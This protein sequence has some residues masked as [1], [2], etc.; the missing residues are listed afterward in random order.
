MTSSSVSSLANKYCVGHGLE[1]G[2]AAHNA[3]G[4]NTLNVDLTD[5]MDTGF[6]QEEIRRCG[7]A[8]P[9]DIVA[10]GDALPVLD[11]SQDFVISS[12]VIE[13][14]PNPIKAL[15]EW[16]RVIRTGG[17]IFMIIPHKDR[18]FDQGASCT[19]LEHLISDYRNNE[20]TVNQ[21]SGRHDHCWLPGDITQ[22][23]NW[24]IKEF[25]LSWEIIDTQDRDDK[26]GNG[27]TVVIRKISTTKR[28]I[29]LVMPFSRPENKD[30]LIQMYKP[31]GITLYPIMFMDE[32][33][34]WGDEPWIVPIM[35]PELSTDCK[36]MMP[37]CYKRNYYISHY[38]IL[39][40]DYY[41]TV[42]DDDFYESN[43]FSEIS[44]MSDDIVI[45]S[46]KRG[47][48][49]PKGVSV[50]RD[51]PTDTLF[52][53]PDN[54]QLGCISAQQPFVKGHIFRN[55]L[56]NESFHCWDGELIVHHRE[57][58]EQIA[59]RPD[60]YALFNYF[61]PGRWDNQEKVFWGC[62]VND[63]QRLSMVLQQSQLS[64]E[65]LNFIQNPESA[66]KGLNYLLDKADGESADIAIL[67][68]QDMYFT[69]EWL[70]KVRSQIKLLPDN[71]VA[72]GPIGKDHT[73]L[74]C[75]KFHDTRIPDWFDTSDIHTFPCEV[76]CFDEAVLIINM[77]SGFRFDEQLTGFDLYGTL[78]ALQAWE[79]GGSVWVIDA[80]CSH[81]CMRSF[82]WHP[83]QLFINNYRW[84]FD[85]F[86]AKWKL[87]S[88][89]LGLSPDAEERVKQM[90]EFMTSAAP[91]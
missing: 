62:M 22:L 58:N 45:I 15:L 49:T 54:V 17:V 84:L 33:I 69:H 23:I 79:S 43:V 32:I 51:Y 71:W 90:R 52:A 28:G 46:M 10:N 19:T 87:D 5:S 67:V 37:G 13:H 31:L 39:P 6:K 36:V 60:L 65:K 85:K 7:K 59:Y 8:L 9:V 30:K 25:N 34:D 44:R 78:I 14:F 42:D 81:H 82:R 56:H 89:A 47:H 50:L 76:C 73:G 72:C 3:F 77:K 68:H 35:I 20:T 75:G 83:D 11:G 4:L 24:M 1:I 61:E 38:F 16:N 88:T 63:P 70:G 40:D 80:P 12:H 74:I 21:E 18:T 27:F 2:G 66:T 48:H 53:H 41:V 29:H 91:E 64:G 57:S 26:V 55:H 86:S